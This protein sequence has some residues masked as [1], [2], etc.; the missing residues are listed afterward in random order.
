MKSQLVNWVKCKRIPVLEGKEELDHTVF[1][2]D[3][4][5]FDISNGHLGLRQCLHAIS[6]DTNL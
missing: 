5:Q 2:I 4:C 6:L 3:L 1:W